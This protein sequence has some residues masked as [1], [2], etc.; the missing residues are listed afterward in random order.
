MAKQCIR[1]PPTRRKRSG[2]AGLGKGVGLRLPT[3]LDEGVVDTAPSRQCDVSNSESPPRQIP[4]HNAHPVVAHKTLVVSAPLN[5]HS[6]PP[7]REQPLRDTE[8][9][10]RGVRTVLRQSPVFDIYQAVIT[11]VVE[12]NKGNNTPSL[13]KSIDL[14]RSA[15]EPSTIQQIDV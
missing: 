12:Q 4:C 6:R 8:A 10:A 13:M 14:L 11:A 7:T 2:G 9:V 3:A 15:D 1:L 5:R